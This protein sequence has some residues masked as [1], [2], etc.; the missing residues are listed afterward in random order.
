MGARLRSYGAQYSRESGKNTPRNTFKGL[1]PLTKGIYENPDTNYKL[2]E[3][4]K[5]VF[6]ANTQIKKI[7]EELESGLEKKNEKKAET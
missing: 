1:S 4:E 5:Q 7:V 3:E 2:L 6:K